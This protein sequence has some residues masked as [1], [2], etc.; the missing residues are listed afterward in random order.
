MEVSQRLDEPQILGLIAGGR[1]PRQQ[2]GL[3]RL[4]LL[5]EFWH[6]ATELFQAHQT[7]LVSS[8]QTTAS[9]WS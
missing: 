4:I 8:F 7:F 9:S 3:N 2:F 6:P 5:A 1:F